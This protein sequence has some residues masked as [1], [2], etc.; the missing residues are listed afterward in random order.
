VELLADE[1]FAQG[2]TSLQFQVFDR[3]GNGPVTSPVYVVRVNSPPV[4]V[5]LSPSDGAD[6]G[7]YDVITLDGS[8]SYDP[9]E[10]DT[11]RYT[12]WSSI[13]GF[14]GSDERMSAPSLSS[15]DHRIVL[16]VSDGVAGH[17]VVQEVNITV[18]PVPSTITDGGEFP[19]FWVL[20]LILAALL[21]VAVL[22]ERRRRLGGAPEAPSDEPLDEPD[23]DRTQAD[24]W[25]LIDDE[26]G[27]G[28]G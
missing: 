28:G 4:A 13:D 27:A 10:E 11:L 15:G 3:A 21:L 20:V 9:D 22:F 17:D 19:W 6:Y 7:P 12:W 1:V 8:G 18:H 2:A 26:E 23:D 25:E 5:L 16:T 24:E 14:I